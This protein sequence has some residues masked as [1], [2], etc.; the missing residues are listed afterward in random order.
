MAPFDRSHQELSNGTITI[1][2]FLVCV[3]FWVLLG[4][5]WHRMVTNIGCRLTFYK[6][7][8]PFATLKFEYSLD[9]NWCTHKIRCTQ[10]AWQKCIPSNCCMQYAIFQKFIIL[11][12][13]V[14]K[15][16][17]NKWDFR[18]TQYSTKKGSNLKQACAVRSCAHL[19]LII[20]DI[21]G[22]RNTQAKNDSLF[23]VVRTPIMSGR[24]FKCFIAQKSITNCL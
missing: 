8:Q 9:H 19:N 5:Y 17:N 6:H 20:I 12:Y 4:F 16:T 1:F 3:S 21:L 2:W 11:V 18:C 23:N 15:K 22:I 14:R 7:K 24:V 13:A 10:Y